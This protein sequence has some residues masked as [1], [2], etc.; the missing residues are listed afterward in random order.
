LEVLGMADI[1]GYP[2]REWLYGEEDFR[3][4]LDELNA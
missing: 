4:W 1:N 2:D 3:A